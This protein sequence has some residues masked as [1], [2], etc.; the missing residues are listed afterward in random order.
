MT[1]GILRNGNFAVADGFTLLAMQGVQ[2]KEV[3][4]FHLDREDPALLHDF[5][6]NGFT[7]NIVAAFLLAGFLVM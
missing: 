1:F 2:H 7:A 6:G 4:A 3:E 5:A